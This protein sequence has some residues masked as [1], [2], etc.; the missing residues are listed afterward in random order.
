[1][2]TLAQFRTS[3]GKQA[4][5]LSD[6]EVQKR[7]DYAYRFSE[8]FYDWFNERKGTG[9][10]AISGAYASDARADAVRSIERIKATRKDV[11]LLPQT[12]PE[13]IEVAKQYEQRY[14]YKN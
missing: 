7:L 1:M 10:E 12:D 4:E 14:P 8:S 9:V 3:L 6:E 11:Y 5:G 13:L 2:V